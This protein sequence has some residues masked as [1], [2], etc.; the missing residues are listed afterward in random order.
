MARADAERLSCPNCGWSNVRSSERAGFWDGAAK[1]LFLSPLRC[2][3]CRL[4][5]Y[6]PW[7]LAKRA[8]PLVADHHAI[9]DSVVAPDPTP[10]A[11]VPHRII[12]LLDD[13]PA[14]RKL[15]GRLLHREGYE[16]REASGAVA[17]AAE[18]RGTGIDLVIV[19]LSAREEEEKAVRALRKAYPEL[20]VVVLSETLALAEASGRLLILPKPSRA[21][22]VVESVRNLISQDPQPGNYAHTRR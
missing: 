3:N 20:V 6:R 14:V 21:F 11:V 4:R 2:R 22:S 19:N 12:L 5:F 15:L 7:F 17:P 9:P 8:L 16:V 13:D 1:L 18:L 10:A